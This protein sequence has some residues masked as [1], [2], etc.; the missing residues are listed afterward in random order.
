VLNRLRREGAIAGYWTNLGHPS[1][2]LGL[3][4]IVARA[5]ERDRDATRDAVT[6]ALARVAPGATVT[7]ADELPPRG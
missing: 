6:R 3:H 7:V 4:V 2:A 1:R 5:E